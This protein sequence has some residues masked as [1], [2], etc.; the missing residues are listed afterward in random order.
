M[1]PLLGH[2]AATPYGSSQRPVKPASRTT[3]PRRVSDN[4]FERLN[5]DTN[6]LRLKPMGLQ[7]R[8]D[9]S[10]L[11][12]TINED[13]NEDEGDRMHARNEGGGISRTHE[14]TLEVAHAARGDPERVG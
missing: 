3:S 2:F 11:R 12:E 4:G 8:A 5:D 9:V 7:Y 14:V 10:A 6:N 13:P 1:R